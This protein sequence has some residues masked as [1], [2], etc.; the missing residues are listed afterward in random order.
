[1]TLDGVGKWTTTSCAIGQ[2]H[3]LKVQKELRGGGPVEACV[4]TL[5]AL[6][7]C[8]RANG[9]WRWGRGML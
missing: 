1:M 7:G 9:K 6:S 3:D 5:R 2:G 8:Q 4:A